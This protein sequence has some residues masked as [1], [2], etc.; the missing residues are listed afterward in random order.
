MINEIWRERLS[1]CDRLIA[2]R[3]QAPFAFASR[4]EALRGAAINTL[5]AVR[6]H[7]LRR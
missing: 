7:L 2:V 1:V 6:R 4:L 3:P 5:K